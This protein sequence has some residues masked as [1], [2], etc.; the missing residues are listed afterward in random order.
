MESML[1]ILAFGDIHGEI[2]KLIRV[3]DH[4]FDRYDVD[5]ILVAGDLNLGLSEIEDVFT[6]NKIP[7]FIIYG[8]H[9]DDMAHCQ[10]T[11]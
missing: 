7:T 8:N 4:A 11:A 2:E 5:M 9:D 10:A 3:L 1:Q 6:Q